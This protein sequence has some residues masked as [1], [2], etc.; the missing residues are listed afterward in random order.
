M[1][2][3]FEFKRKDSGSMLPAP[4]IPNRITDGEGETAHLGY[5][6]KKRMTMCFV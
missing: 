6:Q 4:V 2:L 5:M 1:K 3:D